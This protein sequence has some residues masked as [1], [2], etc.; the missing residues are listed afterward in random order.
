M[1]VAEILLRNRNAKTIGF[2]NELGI[3]RASEFL[4]IFQTKK[5]Y[6]GRLET[7][8]GG[9]FKNFQ[10]FFGCRNCAGKPKKLLKVHKRM[11]AQARQCSAGF[12]EASARE[13]V[14]RVYIKCSSIK[15]SFFCSVAGTPFFSPVE[16][17]CGSSICQKWYFLYIVATGAVVVGPVE[18]MKLNLLCYV[19]RGIR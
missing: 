17:E 12:T 18:G 19:Y 3:I 4:S 16:G 13:S 6:F 2:L 7:H 15:E 11:I 1:T 14:F 9:Y 8:W 5:R 10:Q